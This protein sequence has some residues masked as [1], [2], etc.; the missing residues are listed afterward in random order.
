MLADKLGKSYSYW[1]LGLG[2]GRADDGAS[3][4][5]LLYKTK[6]NDYVF[7]C[8]GVNDV[9]QGYSAD[10]IKKKLQTAVNRLNEAG[11]RVIVQTLP[12]FDYSEENTKKWLEVNSFILSELQRAV[13]PFDCA[14]YLSLC[15]KEP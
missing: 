2:F 7:L 12:P 4:G 9:L 3:N 11:V 15:E 14:K 5:I 8:F 1:N 6:Q 10:A 13:F